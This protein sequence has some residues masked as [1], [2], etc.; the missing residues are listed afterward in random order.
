M[1]DA[2][3]H[4]LLQD[5]LGREKL[6]LLQYVRAAYPWTTSTERELLGKLDKMIVQEQAAGARLAR[7]L[8]RQRL[9]LPFLGNYP[10]FTGINFLSLD[11]VVPLLI[12]HQRKAIAQLERD[13]TCLYDVEVRALVQAIL[14]LKKDHL[15]QLEKM[16]ETVS[17]GT[18]GA[19]Y[20]G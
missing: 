6:S 15:Q 18:L 19:G 12:E 4:R 16:K 3:T 7:Y 13:L 20:A 8:M 10:D 1:I 11:H 9:A 17:A 14:D 5:I 2:A